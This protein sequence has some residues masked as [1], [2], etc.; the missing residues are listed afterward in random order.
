MASYN[1]MVVLLA[2]F[3]QNDLDAKWALGRRSAVDALGALYAGRPCEKWTA[4]VFEA[5]FHA[6][7]DYT[8][9]SHGDIGRLVRLFEN[10][11]LYITIE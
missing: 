11:L 8:T 9:D 10:R 5:L 6:V 7:E 2:Y 3:R 4:P 1:T